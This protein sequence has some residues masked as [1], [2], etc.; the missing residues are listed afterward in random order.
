[1]TTEER[2][3]LILEFSRFRE[4]NQREHGELLAH[5][6]AKHGEVL[7]RIEAVRTEMQAMRA[8]FE[9]AMRVQLLQGVGIAAVGVSAVGLIVRL[10]G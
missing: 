9:R 7:A 10:T 5:S 3:A 2:D 6:E 1:M 8:D 4:Q